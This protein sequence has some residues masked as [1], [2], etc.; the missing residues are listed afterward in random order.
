MPASNDLARAYEGY[1]THEDRPPARTLARRIYEWV[2]AGYLAWSLGYRR[3]EL[4]VWQRWLGMLLCLIP[5]RTAI[6]QFKVM[7]LPAL[8]GG[9]LLDVGCGSG[10]GLQLM[11][12]LGWS[13]T[14]VDFDPAAVLVARGKG[15]DVRAGTVA[16][17]EYPADSFDAVTLSHVIEHLPDPLET[18]QECRRIVKPGGRVVI[19]TPNSQS[20]GRRLFGA[21]WRGLE[22]PRHLQ[23]FSHSAL[24]QLALQAGFRE[25]RGGSCRRGA[26]G[27]FQLSQSTRARRLGRP[28]PGRRLASRLAAHLFCWAE[29]LL[30]GLDRDAGEELALTLIK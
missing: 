20:W 29:G 8:P 23:I 9:R 21:D 27:Y 11:Q 12:S 22:P 17:Q 19:A 14:G 4:P 28:D 16:A 25:V 30:L 5:S 2:C 3:A 7:Y 24:A 13:V 6:A 18:L 1:Y 26:Q 15:L 10:Q